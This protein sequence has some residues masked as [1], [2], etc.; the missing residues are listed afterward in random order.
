MPLLVILKGRT[1]LSITTQ[2]ISGEA[3]ITQIPLLCLNIIKWSV[4]CHQEQLSL[5]H[6][7]FAY[8]FLLTDFFLS[9]LILIPPVLHSAFWCILTLSLF[10]QL[11]WGATTLFLNPGFSFLPTANVQELT[12]ASSISELKPGWCAINAESPIKI[13]EGQGHTRTTFNCLQASFWIHPHV[14]LPIYI[15]KRNLLRDGQTDAEL[16]KLSLST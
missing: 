8:W 3:R 15:V 16:R 4:V 11:I 1:L 9:F 13:H 2:G 12:G 14:W 6:K 5:W 10:L 7:V